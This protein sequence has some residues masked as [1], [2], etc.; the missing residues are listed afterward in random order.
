MNSNTNRE[1]EVKT[2]KRRCETCNRRF[3]FGAI[4]DDFLYL[5][6]LCCGKVISFKRNNRPQQSISLI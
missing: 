4:D 6:C 3:S 1:E 2:I 5:I